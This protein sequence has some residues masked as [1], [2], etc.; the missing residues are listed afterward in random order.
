MDVAVLGAG[1]TGKAAARALAA[2]GA[3]RIR[4]LNRSLERATDLA[5]GL[6][7]GDR[8]VP[9]TL[10]DLP[11]A[12]AECDAVVCATAASRPVVLASDVA[13]ALARRPG[14]RLV[15]VDIAVPRDV[16]PEV[17]G[18][19]GVTLLDLD[20]LE[21]RCALD[22]HDRRREV[23]RIEA[24]AT[25]E[26]EDCAAALRARRAIPDIVALR[27][28]ADAIRRGEWRRFAGRLQRLSP[29]ER[30][31]VEQMTHAIVQKLLHP[32]TVALRHTETRREREALVEA[33]GAAGAPEPP[34]GST[35]ATTEDTTDAAAEE[36][37]EGGT[38]WSTTAP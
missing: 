7:L 10:D 37:T 8:A 18:L 29:A 3:S 9:G 5:A 21:A 15:L 12:L 28:R 27:R 38:I 16:E 24:V 30:A 26:A 17:R 35:E 25:A 6:A 36:G 32:P 13:S 34:V 14:R 2:T 31:A 33:L 19:P 1:V 4:L 11:E 20:D 23:E 22:A